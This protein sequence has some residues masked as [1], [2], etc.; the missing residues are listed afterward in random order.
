MEQ[1]ISSPEFEDMPDARYEDGRIQWEAPSNRRGGQFKDSHHRRREWWARKA[2][3]LGINTQQDKWIS[4]VAK[5]I[6][7]TKSKPCKKCGEYMDIRYVYP[8]SN[9]LK[10]LLKLSFIDSDFQTS[11]TESIYSLITR[12]HALYGQ[13]ALEALPKLLR[14]NAREPF[15]MGD[16]SEWLNW[17]ESVYVPSE[18]K[19]LSPGAMSN[20]PDRFDGF[21]SFNRCC[22]STADT[23]RSTENLRSYSTDRRVFEYWAAGDWIAADRLMGIIRTSFANE[24]CLNDHPGPCQADHI[25]PISLGFN[26]RPYFQL[27][28]GACNSAKNNR[29][30]LSDVAWLIDREKRG[31]NVISWHSKRLW[32][33]CKGKIQ[34]QEH[35]LR[36]SKLLRDNRHSF[37]NA[38]S[39]IAEAGNF[40]FLASLLE[41]DH[42]DWNVEFID[43]RIVNHITTWSD[44]KRT[45]RATKYAAE[46]KSRRS[47]IAFSHLHTYF[48]RQNRNAF[49]VENAESRRQIEATISILSDL[50]NK[51]EEFDLALQQAIMSKQSEADE[52]FRSSYV[53]HQNFDFTIF[54]HALSHLTEHMN[55]I[56]DELGSMWDHER[57]IRE[58]NLQLE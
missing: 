16:L 35:S 49:V 39:L 48:S 18:P 47:R 52:K 11:P 45:P 38:I 33:L 28:C 27:L 25:G 54:K 8:N 9:T 41:L 3:A 14:L 32:D 40:A 13:Q 58:M 15:P 30:Y 4:R 44:I 57:F 24:P 51:T 5:T 42:A 22:R 19:T 21:H 23:G 55:A 36:I 2:Q 1:I 17:I 12:M 37:M 20:A 34:N 7:P 43:L 6:H 53:Q 46:Q 56:G 31:E 10:A 26:H 50:K 29:M